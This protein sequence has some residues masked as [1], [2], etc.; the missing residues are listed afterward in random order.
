MATQHEGKVAAL[1]VTFEVKNAHTHT[2]LFFISESVLQLLYGLVEFSLLGFDDGRL[3]ALAL[4]LCHLKTVTQD[5]D[6]QT[7]YWHAAES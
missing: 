4:E 1:A 2:H 5:L 3:V 6:P 7:T